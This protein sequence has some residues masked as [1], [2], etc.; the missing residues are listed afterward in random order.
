M[1]TIAAYSLLLVIVS[2]FP[3]C[4]QTKTSGQEAKPIVFQVTKSE[5]EWKELLTP[6]QYQVLREKGTEMAFT[7]KYWNN[8]DKGMYFC[9]ACHQALF[10]SKTK[11][12]SGT[13][14]PSYFAPVADS[15][16]VIVNDTSLGMVRDEVL[17]SRCG[18]HLGH[19]FPDGPKPTGLRYCLNSAALDFQEK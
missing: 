15:V 8:H 10:S 6:S 16:V 19:V 7:G 4:S 11:Y 17:C 9:A 18:G 1:K 2:I 3:G 5:Q 12:E 13:G 14:W